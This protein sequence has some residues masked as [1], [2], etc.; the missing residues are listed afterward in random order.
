MSTVFVGPGLLA[1]VLAAIVPS[2]S[3]PRRADRLAVVGAFGVLLW[4]AFIATSY[5]AG[6]SST[7]VLDALLSRWFGLDGFTAPLLPFEALLGL[8]ALVATG[9][10]EPVKT[11]A[12]LAGEGVFLL[13][14]TSLDLDLVVILW[15][16]SFVPGVF[17]TRPGTSGRRAVWFVGL[18]S[19]IP[20][21]IA[22][23]AVQLEGR[24]PF[25]P[26]LLAA[27]LDTY[28]KLFFWS[29]MAAV[30]SRTA[31]FPF[32]TWLFVALERG[33]LPLTALMLCARPGAYLLA[34]IATPIAPET[35]AEALLPIATG[36]LLTAIYGGILGLSAE[37]PRRV[38]GTI[39]MSH[40]GL[41]VIGLCSGSP[42]GITGAL[43]QWTTVGV[44]VMG[45]AL[46]VARL[47]ARLGDLS[48][49]RGL[50]TPLP[51]LS[52]AFLLFG[53]ASVGFPGTLGF[54]GEDLLIHGMLESHPKMAAGMIL[55]TALNGL[56]LMR[57]FMR[58]FFGPVKL[59][60]P[61]PIRMLRRE[62]FAVLALLA[63]VLG[64]GIV[65]APFVR[66]RS[67]DTF[68]LPVLRSGV[69][70]ATHPQRAP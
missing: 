60:A 24:S 15:I 22:R 12:I 56:T 38:L 62:R 9:R 19:T 13:L 57:I 70:D 33:A 65:P 18:V 30:A 64:F 61:N 29:T 28:G 43:V 17:S 52:V 44:S 63:V 16:L 48:R 55:V 66:V 26:E 42:E 25:V 2:I 5:Y 68:A 34:R 36:A 10:N 46:I 51:G 69:L 39:A 31:L 54:I 4:S 32:H 11:S 50:I 40:S 47:E 53:V 41:I 23:I 59:P 45:L 58:I 14:F 6:S 67:P 7:L 20:L 27:P 37:N 35:A 1:L 49:V 21:L 8:A 3:I